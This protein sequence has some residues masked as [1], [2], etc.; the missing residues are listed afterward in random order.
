MEKYKSIGYQHNVTSHDI[1]PM[2]ALLTAIF[3]K[4]TNDYI[5]AYE[6]LNYKP[7]SP[8]TERYKNII[9]DVEIFFGRDDEEGCWAAI[10]SQSRCHFKEIIGVL[11]KRARLLPILEN[12]E[13][14]CPS[15][16][17]SLNNRNYCRHCFQNITY[18]ATENT[19]WM[20]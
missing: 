4:A 11:R 3:E 5:H 1:E 17:A 19:K 2:D 18:E 16:G 10:Y 13:E 8:R 6:N 14:L 15:C 12:G 20:R 7:D 9:E